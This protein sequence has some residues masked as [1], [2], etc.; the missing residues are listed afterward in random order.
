MGQPEGKRPRP[1]CTLGL[2]EVGL[3]GVAQGRDHWLALMK[4]VINLQCP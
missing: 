2:G 1:I 4:A 3:G